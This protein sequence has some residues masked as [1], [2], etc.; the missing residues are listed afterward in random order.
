MKSI[1]TRGKKSTPH[2]DPPDPPRCR[3]N[4]RP[5]HGTYDNDRP[6]IIHIIS[7]ETGEERCWVVGHADKATCQGIIT[8]AVP[9]DGTIVYSDEY[10]SYH[11]IAPAHASVKHGQHEWA[12][13]D[14]GDGVREVHCNTCEGGGAAF[15]TFLRTFRGVHKAYLH[16]YVATYEALVNAKRVTP[17]LICRMCWPSPIS[18]DYWT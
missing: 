17:A 10:R 13:D 4:K 2:R 1:R 7:R 6:P 9:P 15:R 14:D 5:G 3:A 12:R 11:G 16:Y 8:E 18:H